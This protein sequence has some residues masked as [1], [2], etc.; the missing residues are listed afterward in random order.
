MTAASCRSPSAN[1]TTRRL[2]SGPPPVRPRQSLH[3]RQQRLA[4]RLR[5]LVSSPGRREGS[6]RR[7]RPPGGRRRCGPDIDH[8]RSQGP[9]VPHHHP[10]RHVYR[11][12]EVR[13][14]CL[15]PGGQRRIG[16][17]RVRAGIETPGFQTAHEIDRRF[18]DAEAIRLLYVAATRARDHLIVSVHRAIN[19]DPEK[20]GRPGPSRL[21]AQALGEVG[22]AARDVDLSPTTNTLPDAVAPSGRA[23]PDRHMWLARRDDALDLA[24]RPSTVSGPCY[25]RTRHQRPCRRPCSARRGWP[26]R[27]RRRTGR[28]RGP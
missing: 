26:S 10:V 27:H 19:I 14:G 23:L 15:S 18:Q 16:R 25:R 13:P 28:P 21:L 5:R 7:D 3:R 2:A 20:P 12:G 11:Y 24:G 6:G 22:R 17:G 9:G 8:P 1:P 4:A